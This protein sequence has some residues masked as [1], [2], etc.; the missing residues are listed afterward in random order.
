MKNDKNNSFLLIIILLSGIIMTF[1][2]APIGGYGSIA[3][4]GIAGIILGSVG[5]IEDLWIRF[6]KNRY[7]TDTSIQDKPTSDHLCSKNNIKKS[8]HFESVSND[9]DLEFLANFAASHLFMRSLY[10]ESINPEKVLVVFNGLFSNNEFSTTICRKFWIDA[11]NDIKSKAGIS[12]VEAMTQRVENIHIRMLNEIRY[13]LLELSTPMQ[14]NE[15]LYAVFVLNGNQRYYYTVDLTAT[16]TIY[17]IMEIT[18]NT[19]SIDKIQLDVLD[20]VLNGDIDSI[21]SIIQEKIQKIT[22]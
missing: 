4:Y 8:S 12:K 21:C 5:L 9:N 11:Y 13:V 2:I 14:S 3:Y 17:G 7:S 18:G 1:L 22:N 10:L 20:F 19:L 6:R 16:P 15:S